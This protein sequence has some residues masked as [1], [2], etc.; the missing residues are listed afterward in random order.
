MSI[1]CC[2]GGLYH[3]VICSI[4]VSFMLLPGGKNDKNTFLLM[5]LDADKR[6]IR[7][8]ML[9][10]GEKRKKNFYRLK[11][12][13]TLLRHL[14]SCFNG[15]QTEKL[16]HLKW[17]IDELFS[18]CSDTMSSCLAFCLAAMEIWLESVPDGTFWGSQEGLGWEIFSKLMEKMWFWCFYKSRV[19]NK[20]LWKHQ[21]K[22]RRFCVLK[23]GGNAWNCLWKQ[24][25]IKTWR[26]TLEK[27][28]DF[29]KCKYSVTYS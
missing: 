2:S 11:S 14:R 26:K 23:H 25:H 16:L 3:V 13:E 15:I 28:R 7:N 18:D 17:H 5:A 22:L 9:E 20:C 24:K 19:G 29:Y 8:W 10:N 27:I 1:T 21:C 4:G 6:K 12:I